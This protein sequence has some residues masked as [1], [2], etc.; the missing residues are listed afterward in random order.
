MCSVEDRRLIDAIE[1]LTQSNRDL[2][3]AYDALA[4]E[5]AMGWVNFAALSPLRQWLVSKLVG[6]RVVGLE[7]ALDPDEQR[8]ALPPRPHVGAG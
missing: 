3:A 4:R 7:V 8:D 5:H 6:R 2:H 1:R